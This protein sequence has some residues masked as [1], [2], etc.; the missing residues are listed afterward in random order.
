[1]IHNPRKLLKSHTSNY[2]HKSRKEQ[3]PLKEIPMQT[4]KVGDLP[5]ENNFLY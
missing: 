5:I 4:K 2:K 3:M 1:M